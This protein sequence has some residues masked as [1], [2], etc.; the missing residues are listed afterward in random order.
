VDSDVIIGFG[1]A[2]LALGSA[3]ASGLL[4]TRTNNKD[5]EPVAAGTVEQKG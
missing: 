1:S 5:I 3:N 2:V 4:A